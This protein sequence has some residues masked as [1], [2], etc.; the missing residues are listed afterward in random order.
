MYRAHKIK[1]VN[2]PVNGIMETTPPL[3]RVKRICLHSRTQGAH[4]ASVLHIEAVQWP[5]ID[6][7]RLVQLRNSPYTAPEL[8][9][10]ALTGKVRNH[11]QFE[12][13]DDITTSRVEWIDVPLRRAKSGSRI[14]TL[15]QMSD[16]YREFLLGN[17]EN[18]IERICATKHV[19]ARIYMH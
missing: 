2:K 15:G 1:S 8:G 10:L 14:Y 5:S 19:P 6:E 4:P 3:S 13:G 9:T 7:W 12:D 18:A 17:S 16:A 11:P